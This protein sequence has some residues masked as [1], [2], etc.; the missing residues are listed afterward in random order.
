MLSA[1]FWIS[2]LG[3]VYSYSLYPAILFVLSRTQPEKR[4]DTSNRFD[5]PPSVSLVITAYNE[6]RNI[7]AKLDDTLKLKYPGKLEIIVASDGSTDDTDMLVAAYSDKGVKLV[8]PEQRL[9]KENAQKYAIE[10]CSGSIVVFSDVST[11]I[12]EDALVHAV[13]YFD[14]PQIGAISSEDRFIANEQN[15]MPGEGMYVRYEM[16]L[17]KLESRLAGLVGLSGSFFAARINICHNWDIRSPSDF[18]TALQCA[19]QGYK[20]VTAPD[21]LGYYKDL[22]DPKK[23]Y[24]RKLRTVIRGMTAVSR[25]PACLNP[26]KFGLF[27]FQLFS[28]KIMRWLVPCFMVFALVLNAILI[29][30]SEALI[31]PMLFLGQIGFYGI[32]LLGHALPSLQSYTL[33]RLVLFFVRVNLALLHAGIQFIFGKRMTVWEPSKR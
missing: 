1:A 29:A 19:Q 25:N 16:W 12:P 5:A 17:R 14:D 2:L 11:K 33:V 9:G 28:H 23:E 6:E 13:K 4:T 10:R 21:V 22:A 8:R 7:V 27:A 3:V 18:N 30:S 15:D 20:A 32:A 24:Q 31:Y 26:F